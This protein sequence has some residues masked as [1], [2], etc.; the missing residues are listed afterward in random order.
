MALYIK[1]DQ[2]RLR[3]STI[4]HLASSISKKFHRPSS[5]RCALAQVRFEQTRLISLSWLVTGCRRS[6]LKRWHYLLRFLFP[7]FNRSWPHHPVMWF[8]HS[9]SPSQ[10]KAVVIRCHPSPTQLLK[11]KRSHEGNPSQSPQPGRIK[12]KTLVEYLLRVETI[13]VQARNS[14]GPY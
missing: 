10:I 2:I 5:K 14:S 3:Y 4:K 1:T 8:H 6:R 12:L 9:F 11:D 7:W 13:T